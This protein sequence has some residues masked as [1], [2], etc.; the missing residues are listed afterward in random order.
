MMLLA[1]AVND[2][3]DDDVSWM[4]MIRT[5]KTRLPFWFLTLLEPLIRAL[6]SAGLYFRAPKYTNRS[7]NAACAVR[8]PLGD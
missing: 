3:D 8:K 4:M 1:A 6:E 5:E 7:N 2:H